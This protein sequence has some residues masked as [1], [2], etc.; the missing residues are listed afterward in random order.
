MLIWKI[1]AFKKIFLKIK[2]ETINTF[3]FLVNK[4]YTFLTN[5]LKFAIYDDNTKA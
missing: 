4:N 3:F 5:L 1:F 2:S